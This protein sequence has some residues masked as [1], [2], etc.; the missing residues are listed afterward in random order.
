M[1]SK[2]E[3]FNDALIQVGADEVN[4][5]D[6]NSP[7]ARAC[8][9]RFNGA[10]D[11]VLRAHAWNAASTRKVI[12]KDDD[13]PAFGYAFQYTLPTDPFCLRP[14]RVN[15]P[16]RTID[17]EEW[18]VEGR[19]ILTDL[20]PP[21]N[22]LYVQ[23]LTDTEQWDALLSQA[24]VHRLAFNI[25]YRVTR[26]RAKEVEAREDYF[27]FLAEARTI[28]AQEGSAEEVITDDF[29]QSRA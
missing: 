5:P 12:P 16:R 20:E 24:I 4:S 29:I 27:R 3:I 13:P 25:A 22:L 7:N 19:K 17:R 15:D 1:A 2:V 10:R 14:L 11:A 26:S 8:R 23:R 28:D 18:K 21:L 9:V 6:E